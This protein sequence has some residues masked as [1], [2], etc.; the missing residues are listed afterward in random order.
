MGMVP[1]TESNVC[2]YRYSTSLNEYLLIPKL[3]HK[4]KCI[5]FC[6]FINLSSCQILSHG[7]AWNHNPLW[8]HAMPSEVLI[9]SLPHKFVCYNKFLYAHFPFFLHAVS[10]YFSNFIQIG[11]LNLWWT[12]SQ[13][14]VYL[15]YINTLQTHLPKY[16]EIWFITVRST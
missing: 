1:G 4:S 11:W 5:L 8:F 9:P 16:S 12:L 15:F 10:N 13:T 7:M 2:L 6:E 3:L 14:D